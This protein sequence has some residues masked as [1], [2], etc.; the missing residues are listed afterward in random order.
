MW[1]LVSPVFGVDDLEAEEVSP[2]KVITVF[3]L[4]MGE[5]RVAG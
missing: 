4:V 3:T 5:D 1:D 2:V